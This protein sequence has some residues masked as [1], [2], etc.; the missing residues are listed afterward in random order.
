MSWDCADLKHYWQIVAN[1]ARYRNL[2]HELGPGLELVASEPV[3]VV[4]ARADFATLLVEPVESDTACRADCAAG[5]SIWLWL[6]SN[7]QG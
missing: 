4:V 3:F 5:L 6:R 7:L 2:Y 1:E